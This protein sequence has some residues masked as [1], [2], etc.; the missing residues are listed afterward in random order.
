MK[1]EVRG[2]EAVRSQSS[3]ANNTIILVIIIAALVILAVVVFSGTGVRYAAEDPGDFVLKKDCKNNNKNCNTGVSDPDWNQMMCAARWPNGCLYLDNDCKVPK[4]IK[5]SKWPRDLACKGI[6]DCSV[7][8]LK[9]ET[10]LF[11]DKFKCECD[12]KTN[13]DI[14]D[15]QQQDGGTG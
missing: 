11:S 9:L 2:R 13:S 3:S 8:C 14:G 15:D 1:R 6:A 7:D 10:G 12:K 4:N 5:K